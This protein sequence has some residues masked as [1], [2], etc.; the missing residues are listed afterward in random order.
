MKIKH[1]KTALMAGILIL[2]NVACEKSFEPS[3]AIDESSALSSPADIETATIGTYALF[4]LNILL[5]QLPK[6]K[7]HRMI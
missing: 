5:M 4:L 7:T 2:A 1:V 3:T 6:G